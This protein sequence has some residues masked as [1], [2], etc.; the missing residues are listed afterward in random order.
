MI[1]EHEINSS[2][3]RESYTRNREYAIADLKRSGLEPEDV[4]AIFPVY[5]IASSFLG[6]AGIPARYMIPYFYRDGTPIVDVNGFPMMYRTR[7]D[8]DEQRYV[9]PSREQ[10][11][12]LSLFPYF[13]P[14]RFTRQTESKTYSIVEG[15]KK[16]AKFWKETGIPGCAI[17]CCWNWK[18][19]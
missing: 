12:A 2:Q 14:K 8:M 5:P 3:A 15:E 6:S 11:G 13:S 17:G 9:Q 16:Y 19:G 7:Q 1:R 10:I 4:F 18:Y